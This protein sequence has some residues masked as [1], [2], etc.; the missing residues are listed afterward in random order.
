[1]ASTIRK[2]LRKK[3]KIQDSK[4]I[5]SHRLDIKKLN[6]F[7]RM[8]TIARIPSVIVKTWPIMIISVKMKLI[9]MKKVTKRPGGTLL[10]RVKMP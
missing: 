9:V 4:K 8:L 1:M 7:P 5:S 2:E 6:H 10:T 3:G